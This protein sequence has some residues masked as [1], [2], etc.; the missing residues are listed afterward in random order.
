LPS[1]SEETVEKAKLLLKDINPQK[2]IIVISPAT[3]WLNKHWKNEYWA[4]L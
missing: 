1:S 2:P 4:K 3:T